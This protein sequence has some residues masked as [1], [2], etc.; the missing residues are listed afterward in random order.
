MSKNCDKKKHHHKECRAEA[1][2]FYCKENGHRRFDCP[3]LKRKDHRLSSATQSLATTAASVES[4][5]LP[6]A[7]MIATVNK[8]LATMKVNNPFVEV[9]KVNEKSAI[10]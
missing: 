2:C 5:D 4:I 10:F 1:T 9:N 7:S 6:I 8:V 3:T